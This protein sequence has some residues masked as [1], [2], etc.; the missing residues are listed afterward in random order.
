MACSC[1]PFECVCGANQ[2][3]F[4]GDKINPTFAYM[5]VASFGDWEAESLADEYRAVHGGDWVDPYRALVEPSRCERLRLSA[6]GDT[7]FQLEHLRRACPD[8]SEPLGSF[9]PPSANV[10][11]DVDFSPCMYASGQPR[12]PV[13]CRVAATYPRRAAPLAERGQGP[14][15]SYEPPIQSGELYH[16]S[17]PATQS[18]ELY[19]TSEVT[20]RCMLD[21][22]DAAEPSDILSLEPSDILSLDKPLSGRL[23]PAEMKYTAGGVKR[24]SDVFDSLL[25]LP[26][27]TAFLD[28]G[29]DA[30]SSSRHDGSSPRTDVTDRDDDHD[31]SATPGPHLPP[32]GTGLSTTA[33]TRSVG[34][35]PPSLTELKPIGVN[36]EAA[37]HS[38]RNYHRVA[39]KAPPH[40]TP[41]YHRRQ[42]TNYRRQDTHSNDYRHHVTQDDYRRQETHS[43]DYRRQDT[44]DDDYRRQD[45]HNIDYKR[46]DTHSD[47][48]RRAH[49]LYR[50]HINITLTYT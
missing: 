8:Y 29:D 24:A 45:I 10:K 42:D 22:F 39:P 32:L 27:I 1:L 12:G 23:S 18:G 37:A 31:F 5:S 21:D 11:I 25:S 19:Y 34:V 16:P 49:S 46:Q 4:L 38:A 48:Y 41:D 15:G 50:N 43:T 44:Q 26:A 6:D 47:D 17:D 40:D 13:D 9:R 30:F 33:D 28:N 36:R 20:A 7:V 35:S 3:V 2:R 14:V